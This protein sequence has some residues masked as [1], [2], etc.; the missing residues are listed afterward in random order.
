MVKR[1]K[2]TI[3]QQRE[4]E[5]I[6]R[7]HLKIKKLLINLRIIWKNM[8]NRKQT[9]GTNHKKTENIFTSYNF[10]LYHT[11]AKIRPF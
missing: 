4:D 3:R 10:F 7:S 5:A 2:G 11:Y 6:N 1:R 9:V 8:F